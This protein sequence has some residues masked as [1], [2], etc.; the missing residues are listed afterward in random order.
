M[1]DDIYNNQ[2]QH[3]EFVDTNVDHAYFYRKDPEQKQAE[4]MDMTVTAFTSPI[5]QRN[6]W[7]E[8]S[9]RIGSTADAVVRDY[10]LLGRDATLNK[11]YKNLS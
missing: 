10:F 2:K 4:R 1:W 5:E 7:L 3:V 8:V 9:A 6:A 11:D